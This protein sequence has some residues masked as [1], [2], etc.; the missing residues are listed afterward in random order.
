MKK[1]EITINKENIADSLKKD[2]L[3]RKPLL[4]QL[5]RL[6]NSINESFTLSIDGD[7]GSGKTFFI[8][9][10][11]FLHSDDSDFDYY[12][13]Q[14]DKDEIKKFKEKY[15]PIYYNAWENDNHDNVI[16]SLIYNILD[17]YPKYKNDPLRKNQKFSNIVK[18]LLIKLIEKGTFGF[19]SKETLEQVDSFDALSETIMTTEEIKNGLYEIFNSITD[20]N[21]R[22]LLI[23]DE[24]DR[25]KP[26]YAVKTLETIKH[27]Y[28][29]EKITCLVV[30]NN[31][32]LSESIKHF[33]GYNFNG[34]SYLNKMYDIILSLNNLNIDDYLKNILSFP[35]NS[36]L[37]EEISYILVHYFNMS[38]RECNSFI[39]MYNISL[40]YFSLARG[41]NSEKYLAYSNVLLPIGLALKVKNIAEF[42][43]YMNGKS[44]TFFKE[45]ID[46]IEE[47]DNNNK[48]D[49]YIPWL[50]RVFADDSNSSLYDNMINKYTN[51]IKNNKYDD[52]PLLEALSLLGKHVTYDD[53]IY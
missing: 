39:N 34:Y 2:I 15:I 24:L 12:N 43:K 32:Q 35:N 13:E 50:K 23:I 3:K 22:I 31:N 25:C 48:Y 49:K 21:T 1:N 20:N 46:F 7:W 18:P 37:S 45:L 41:F 4:I 6:V 51:A 29:Y 53:E 8:K 38:L 19:I 10:L 16:S 9:Q 30:T 14:S 42:S 44:N 40:N 27:F 33:Y 36:R 26:D 5:I 17:A 47:L 11:L 52:F 28:D